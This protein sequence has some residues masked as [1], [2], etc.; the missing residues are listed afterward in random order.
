[1]KHTLLFAGV[2]V[3]GIY[4]LSCQ[5][6]AESTQEDT[7][8]TG[9]AA[10]TREDSIKRGEYLSHIMG[11]NDCHTP[12]VMTDR[13]PALDTTRLL[14]GHPA[15][16]PLPKITDKGMIGPGQWV[17]F[18]LG[19]TAA[20]GPWGTSFS[21][22]LTPDETGIGSWTLENFDQA[23]RHGKFKGIDGG[24]MIMPPMPWQTYSALSDE[25]LSNLWMYL[26]S[27][28]PVKN[29]VP[30]YVPPMQG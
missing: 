13:G 15:D 10:M 3:A 6:Q 18:S 12:K 19:Q 9:T 14:S 22:N 26:R 16:E 20:V 1:M 5:K 11:C 25:D 4:L 27:L 24:R 17:L 23:I 2:F 21:A 28:K 29:M 8:S 7:L 30:A